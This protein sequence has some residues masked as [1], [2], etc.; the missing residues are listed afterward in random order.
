MQFD[1]QLTIKLLIFINFT[2]G[3]CQLSPYSLT[4]FG[5]WTLGAKVFNFTPN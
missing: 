4:P 2:L 1:P 5:K 3:F